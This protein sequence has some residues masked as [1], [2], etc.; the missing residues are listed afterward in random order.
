MRESKKIEIPLSKAKLAKLFLFSL[1]FEGAGLW[2]LIV[3]PQISNPVFNNSLF[4]GVASSGAIIL[5][6]FGIYFYSRKL[7]DKKPGLVLDER[8]L[9]DNTSA[10][11]FGLI[12]W[13]D[14]SQIHERTVR[15]SIFSRQQFVTIGLVN[16]DKYI[17]REKN[18]VK[19]KLLSVNASSYGSPV[20]LST[21][22]LKTNHR[23][24]LQMLTTEHT[25]HKSGN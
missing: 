18:F 9:Y 25:K 22:G 4:K 2:L 23:E 13:E 24:L 10:F 7:F 3:N 16:P 8:G 6:V 5:G 11:N 1:L 14:I 20:H 15:A 17:L 19:R 21:N 12:P